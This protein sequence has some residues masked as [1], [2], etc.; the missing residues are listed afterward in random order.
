M[1]ESDEGSTSVLFPGHV[2]KLKFLDVKDTFMPKTYVY[3]FFMH[4]H[5]SQLLG[6]YGTQFTD[7]D[8]I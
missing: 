2:S 7:A 1:S 6:Y 3:N 8:V 5:L 4:S